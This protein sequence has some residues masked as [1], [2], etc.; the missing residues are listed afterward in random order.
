MTLA[1]DIRFPLGGHLAGLSAGS[2]RFG[3]RANNLSVRRRA[4]SD[5][6]IA[7]TI[8]LAEVSG[9]ETF[10]HAR[11]NDLSM[12][13]QET[14]VHGFSLG[15]ETHVYLNPKRLFAFDDDS[16]GGLAAA[17]GMTPGDTG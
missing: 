13:V 12:V 10:V 14:G 17:P 9:S 4:D 2:Y 11:H 5:V 6:E 16:G 15:Q 3:A 1:Y 8:E 7:V